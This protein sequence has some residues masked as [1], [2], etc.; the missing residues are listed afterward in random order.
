M[1]LLKDDAM[2]KAVEFHH[3]FKQLDIN[4]HN[5]YNR[6]SIAAYEA[7]CSKHGGSLTVK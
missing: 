1:K 3:L 6:L 4:G 2:V 7:T 5:V